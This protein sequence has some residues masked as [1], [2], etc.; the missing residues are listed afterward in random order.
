MLTRSWQ[1]VVLL[2]SL[3]LTYQLSSSVSPDDNISVD[4]RSSLRFA[5]KEGRLNRNC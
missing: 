2:P 1:A 5:E 3:W 4:V